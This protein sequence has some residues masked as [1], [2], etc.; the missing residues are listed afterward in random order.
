MPR[1]H[2]RAL[3]PSGGEV[4]G[5]LVADDERD[6]AVQ[7]QAVGNYPIEIAG[8]TGGRPRS[9]RFV[10]RS[11]HIAARD[12]ILFTRQL[13]TLLGAGV[14]LDRA[15]SLIAEGGG[16][17][18]RRRLAAELLGAINRGESFSRACANQSAMPRH[19][20]MFVAAGE[21]RG[22]IA[23]ALERL[24]QVM[25]RSRAASRAL[26]D[27]LIYPAS[28]MV[29]ACAS[30]SFLLGFVL[31]RF[32]VLLTSLQ[33]DPPLAMQWLMAFSSLFQLLALPS[34]I[35]ALAILGFFA[36]RNR[37]PAFRLA[38]H[39][40]L[41][42][43]PGLGSLIGKIEAER[44]LHLLGNLVSAGVQLPAAVAATRAAMTS[45]AFRAGL[46]RTE[47]AI[48]RGE[49]VGAALAASGVLPGVAAELV[50]VGEETGD[51]APMLLN[52][53]EVLRREFE[54]MSLELIGLVTPI[55]ILVL[56]LLIGAV[57]AAILGT[58]MQVYDVAG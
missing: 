37:D 13:A 36:V 52:A 2:Y 23:A 49:G 38:L 47:Q 11:G 43:L 15:L 19:Y 12:L 7:L 9:G 30:I 34:A 14:A 1:F 18:A 58:V 56:G 24:G 57:A 4:V 50:R 46:A 5:E 41:L 29:V 16:R 39:R 54:A 31:P 42:R 21:A 32:E 8:A 48:D 55:S 3:R 45:E 35:V 28:V 25:E 53:G 6:V 20:A 44:L 40:R 17:A 51:L 22:D 33:R 27:A 26:L 10:V